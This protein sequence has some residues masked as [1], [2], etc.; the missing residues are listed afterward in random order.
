MFY[1]NKS[2]RPV[3]IVAALYM[4][5]F[6]WLYLSRRNYEF[7]VHI[8]VLLFFASLILY[9][10]R[11][12]K[13]PAWLLWGLAI[14]GFVHMSGG[15]F[16]LGETR[17][18]ELMLIQISQALQIFR[19]DQAVHIFGFGVTTLVFHHILGRP[20]VGVAIGIVL[21]M[22]G[23]G[24]GA[25]YEI[26]EFLA[27][28]IVAEHGVGGYINNSLDLLSNFLGALLALV[29]IKTREK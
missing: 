8:V 9:S 3:A 1:L 25:L 15:A 2:Q 21:V 10:N 7:L 14:W 28:L 17:L 27:T 26:I 29:L 23:T 22:A 11:K 18:Y 5:F 20:R 24:A 4:L 6:T 16:Y 12:V 13:Y 19:Y